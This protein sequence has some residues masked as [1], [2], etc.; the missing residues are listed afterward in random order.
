MLEIK[1]E[2]WRPT[3]CINAMYTTY[4][5]RANRSPAKDKTWPM[6]ASDMDMPRDM[7]KSGRASSMSVVTKA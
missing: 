6:A 2:L 3:A 1:S 7:Q 4:C 5:K